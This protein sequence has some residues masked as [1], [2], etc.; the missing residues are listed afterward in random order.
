MRYLH[1][2]VFMQKGIVMK[3]I[4]KIALITLSPDFSLTKNL[5]QYFNNQRKI[6]KNDINNKMKVFL[7]SQTLSML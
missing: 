2:V 5:K 1:N 4:H 6:F 3:N 7:S